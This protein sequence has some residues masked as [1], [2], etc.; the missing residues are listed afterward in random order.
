M[1]GCSVECILNMVMSPNLYVSQ[2]VIVGMGG[3]VML[4][5]G[6]IKTSVMVSGLV[7][8]KTRAHA[9]RIVLVLLRLI[10]IGALVKYLMRMVLVRV[11]HA[12]IL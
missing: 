2:I 1:H 10:L 4:E 5:V 8:Q 11:V 3:V 7:V 9:L 12:H 6:L